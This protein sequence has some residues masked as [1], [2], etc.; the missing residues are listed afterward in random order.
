M[1]N[2]LGDFASLSKIIVSIV[3]WFFE[4]LP[5][6]GIGAILVWLTWITRNHQ[7]MVDKEALRGRVREAQQQ[8]NFL[9]MHNITV[10]RA[11]ELIAGGGITEKHTVEDVKRAMYLCFIQINRVHELWHGWQSKILDEP[12][13]LIEVRPML[14]LLLGE[15]EI[16]NYCLTRG[17][18]EDFVKFIID[19]SEYVLQKLPAL[20]DRDAWV[21]NFLASKLDDKHND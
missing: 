19:E 3:P 15:R 4:A 16:F 9:A 17:Y 18:P 21:K 2:V 11:A 6:I 20:D 8:I 12:E 10:Q 7:R 1:E 14:N 13:M 5:E